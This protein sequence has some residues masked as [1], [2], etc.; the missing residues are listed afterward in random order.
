MTRDGNAGAVALVLVKRPG[1][2]GWAE[3]RPKRDAGALG[4]KGNFPPGS[5]RCA[6]RGSLNPR[7]PAAN[8]LLP[9]RFY[10]AAFVNCSSLFLT[11]SEETGG[12][13]HASMI[14]PF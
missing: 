4:A 11:F 3:A 12:C 9:N 14:L 2:Q 8:S 7:E 10:S 1:R 13:L 6:G 5:P